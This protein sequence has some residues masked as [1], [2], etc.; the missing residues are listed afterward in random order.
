MPHVSRRALRAIPL[1]LALVASLAFA[2]TALGHASIGPGHAV[3]GDVQPFVI[4]VP[5]EK[6]GGVLTTAVRLTVP[7]GFRLRAAA[8]AP[9]WTLRITREGSGEDIRISAVEW[10]GGES[11]AGDT[12]VFDIV[13]SSADGGTYALPVRQTYS[14]GSVV[15]WAGPEDADT[16]APVVE[17]GSASEGSDTLAIIA[18]IV[19]VV[20]VLLG[21][22]ALVTRGRPAA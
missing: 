4:V 8:P 17:V 10:T 21:G 5:N 6:E 3:T 13:G 16:P 11:P 22:A 12:A 18:L 1:A 9:G 14:D 15:D 19:G 7:E 2:A 20:G